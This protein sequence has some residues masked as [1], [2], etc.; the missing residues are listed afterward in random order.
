MGRPLH[1]PGAA[2]DE[3]EAK[4]SIGK[5]IRQARKD[6]NLSQIELS[7]ETGMLS[8]TVSCLE[9]GRTKPGALALIQLALALDVSTDWLLFGEAGRAGHKARL[10]RDEKSCVAGWED[11][12]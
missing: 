3:F 11:E 5:R 2:S 10:M 9:S 8:S 7:T 4:N 1:I 6:R 12:S